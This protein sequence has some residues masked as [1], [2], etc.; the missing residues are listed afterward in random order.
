MSQIALI[1][2]IS[3][4]LRYRTMNELIGKTIPINDLESVEQDVTS[5]LGSMLPE[6]S[7]LIGPARKYMEGVSAIYGLLDL[8]Y[9]V[10]SSLLESQYESG[11]SLLKALHFLI[12]S[13]KAEEITRE[14]RELAADTNEDFNDPTCLQ[15]LN[16]ALE[17][18]QT[19]LR[20]FLQTDHKAQGRERLGLLLPGFFP[21]EF[22]VKDACVTNSDFVWFHKHFYF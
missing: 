14:M 13:E 20:L 12:D 22:T 6:N 17:T 18:K 7:K 9:T 8:T 16:E 3:R 5:S 4:E 11:I 19:F 21:R 1:K 10:P 15:N 2:K